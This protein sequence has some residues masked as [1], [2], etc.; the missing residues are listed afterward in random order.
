M[1]CTFVLLHL[2][3]IACTPGIFKCQSYN[4]LQPGV[5]KKAIACIKLSALTV[6]TDGVYFIEGFP[7]STIGCEFRQWECL[8]A[9]L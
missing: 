6:A 5:P 8:Q 2:T 4:V 1:F 7:E 9:T 3:R